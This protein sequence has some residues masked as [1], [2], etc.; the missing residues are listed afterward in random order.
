M[1]FILVTHLCFIIKFRDAGFLAVCSA[2][3]VFIMALLLAENIYKLLNE[4]P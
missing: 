3:V 1:V 4:K 2:V